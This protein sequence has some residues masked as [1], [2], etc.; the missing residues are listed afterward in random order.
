MSELTQREFSTAVAATIEGAHHFYREIGRLYVGL[1]E[2]LQGEPNPFV[3]LGGY[4]AKPS[5]DPDRTTVRSFFGQLFEPNLSGEDSEEDEEEDDE[6]EGEDDSAPKSKRTPAVIVANQPLLI[7]KLKLFDPKLLGQFDPE[8]QYAVLGD[9]ICGTS[10]RK[11]TPDEQYLL[12]RHMIR[13]IVK[14][15]DANTVLPDGQWTMTRAMVKAK[16]GV[17][18]Q[19]RRLGFRVLGKAKRTPIFNLDTGESIDALTNAIQDHWTEVVG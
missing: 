17:K 14:A 3:A 18:S 4:V 8:V 5:R 13:R 12:A 1:R 6:T 19:D 11:S 15:F 2:A 10:S 7:V 16:R 9:W